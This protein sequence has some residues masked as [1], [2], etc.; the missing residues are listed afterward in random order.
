MDV[1]GLNIELAKTLEAAAVVLNRGGQKWVVFGGA[2]MALH[3]YDVGVVSDVD[4]LVS[5]ETA[6][7]LMKEL[8]VENQA[9]ETS[10]R[11]RSDYL[12]RPSLGAVPIEVLADFRIF[13]RGDWQPIH[14]KN[15]TR[16]EVRGQTVFVLDQAELADVFDLCG[17]EKDLVRSRMLRS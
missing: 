13:S 11:F 15:V 10:P 9:D 3:G 16:M 12:L 17:R 7:W 14:P 8:A 6:T 1:S 4:I 5:A 2:A